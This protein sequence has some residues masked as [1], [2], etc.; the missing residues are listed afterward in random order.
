MTAVDTTTSWHMASD[1]PGRLRLRAHRHAELPDLTQIA[2]TL[3]SKPGVLSV[4][5]NE[6]TRSV[7]IQ[8]GQHRQDLLSLLHDAGI[9]FAEAASGGGGS[10]PGTEGGS[11]IERAV[12]DLEARL[13]GVVGR[14]IKVRTVIPVAL[15]AL[16]LWRAFTCG[17]GLSQVPALFL[18]WYAFDLY[19]KFNVNP[20]DLFPDEESASNGKTT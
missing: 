10:A 11:G 20:S 2:K 5:T 14:D 3:G 15:G 8:Y 6:R 17:L 13:R 1:S 18:L 9:V 19:Y 16:G 7:L 12:T 4:E